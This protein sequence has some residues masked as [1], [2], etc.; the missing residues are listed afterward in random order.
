MTHTCDS[1]DTLSGI[2]WQPSQKNDDTNPCFYAGI[3]IMGG[4]AAHRLNTIPLPEIKNNARPFHSLQGSILPPWERE[5]SCLFRST[6]DN[7]WPGWGCGFEDFHLSLMTLHLFVD[8]LAACSCGCECMHVCTCFCV[9][10]CVCLYMRMR[11]CVCVNCY[12]C[13]DNDFWW[14]LSYCLQFNPLENIF[15][16][17]K[18]IGLCIHARWAQARASVCMCACVCMLVHVCERMGYLITVQG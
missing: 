16:V 2:I 14:V 7:L 11:V 8:M 10:V 3:I 5:C 1:N 17:H 9:C 13:T 4:A 6:G 15:T 18:L 12:L